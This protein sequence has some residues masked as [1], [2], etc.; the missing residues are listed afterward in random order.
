LKVDGD[1][2]RIKLYYFSYW[3]DWR[4]TIVLM[5]WKFVFRGS[6]LAIVIL[7]IGAVAAFLYI[8]RFSVNIPTGPTP[9]PPTL[10]V[11]QGSFPETQVGLKEWAKYGG[12]DYVP[13]GNG[14]FLGMDGGNVIGVTTAHSVSTFDSNHSL[15]KIAFSIADQPGFIAE[16]DTLYG[17]P[18]KPR[19]GRD[20][21]VDFILLRVDDTVDPVLVLSPDPRGEPQAG[22]RILL[23]SGLGDGAGGLCVY[24]GTI[25]TVG[26]NGAWAVM[27]DDFSP[28]GMSGSPFLSEHTGKVVGMAIVTGSSEGRLMIGMHTIGSLVMK[29]EEAKSFPRLTAYHR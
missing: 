18:G 23:Y 6:I 16:M 2:L 19:Y 14:F 15:A 20:M 12:N 26:E 1:N 22:E 8:S 11:P 4:G 25:M 3:R 10:L 13:V 28:A 27:D 7:A 24:P 9:P 29:V 17:E 5:N 21:T